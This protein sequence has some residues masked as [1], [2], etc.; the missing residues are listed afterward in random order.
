M[1]P[2]T[3][4]ELT[5]TDEVLVALRQAWTESF[6]LD[7]VLRHEEGGWIFQNRQSGAI[8]IVRADSG[9]LDFIELLDPPEFE[10]EMLVATFHTHP[11]PAAEGWYTGP[12]E[13]DT[14]SGWR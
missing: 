7:P 1:A 9:E 12:S 6:P 8:H 5:E 4:W 10:G 14:D 3:G 2:L 13:D 11:N